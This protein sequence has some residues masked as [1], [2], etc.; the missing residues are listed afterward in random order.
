MKPLLVL[1]RDGVLNELIYDTPRGRAPREIKEVK[2]LIKPF[3]IELLRKRYSIVCISNQPDLANNKMDLKTLY[4]VHN[5]VMDKFEIAQSFICTHNNLDKCGC[6]KPL[7][8]L[9]QLALFSNCLELPA[10][11]I[12]D[13]WT[14]IYA[15]KILGWT[16]ILLNLDEHAFEPTTQG[17]APIDLK[18][19]YVFQKWNDALKVLVNIEN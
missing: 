3:E 6:R 2:Y 11:I 9:L 15:G 5:K 16:T 19:D 1:D 13:R 18:P 17:P 4:E 8:M 10:T 12:G 14:D 7:T